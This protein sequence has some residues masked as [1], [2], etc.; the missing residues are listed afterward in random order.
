VTAIQVDA[1]SS[2]DLDRL[3]K[4][5]AGESGKLGIVAAIGGLVEPTKFE[6]VAEEFR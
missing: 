4:M 3:F 5:G 2:A 1:T 6:D